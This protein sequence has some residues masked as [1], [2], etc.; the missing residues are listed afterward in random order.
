MPRLMPPD[1]AKVLSVSALTAEVKSLLEDGFASVWVAG[2]ISGL[3]RPN[4][5]HLYLKLK[6][7]QAVL[8][9]CIWR[10]TALR[11]RFEPRDGL[12]VIARGRL[13]VYPPRGDY[14]L[15]IEELH[16]KGLG[17]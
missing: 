11:L 1:D 5:G 8:G 15:V 17:A 9:A 12:E 7:S 2:E 13:T 16:P 6:D 10:S 14:Q 4:S 3:A